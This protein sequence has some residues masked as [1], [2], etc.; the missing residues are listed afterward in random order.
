MCKTALCIRSPCPKGRAALGLCPSQY[1]RTRE[2]QIHVKFQHSLLS[3]LPASSFNSTRTRHCS[4][5][6]R[7]ENPFETSISESRMFPVKKARALGR[8]LQPGLGMVSGHLQPLLLEQRWSELLYVEQEDPTGMIFYMK[9]A[10]AWL[11]NAH[12]PVQAV[13]ANMPDCRWLV[14]IY[15][16]NTIWDMFL[17]KFEMFLYALF[18]FCLAF[19]YSPIHTG[20]RTPWWVQTDSSGVNLHV[21]SVKWSY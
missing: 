15:C 10:I 4:R 17:V 12:S 8:V 6:S 13:D 21:A 19:E 2:G 16:L 20:I 14:C 11:S 5:P 7:K 1:I 18:P 3:A 9:I